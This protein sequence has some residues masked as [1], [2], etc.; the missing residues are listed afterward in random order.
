MQWLGVTSDYMASVTSGLCYLLENNAVTKLI[1]DGYAFVRD[2]ALMKKM[3][4]TLRDG[5]G[6][7]PALTP[8]DL[9]EQQK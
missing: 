4:D 2:K 8:K 6:Y 7:G 9:N 3:R 5:E 1:I